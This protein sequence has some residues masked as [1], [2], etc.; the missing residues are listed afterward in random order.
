MSINIRILHESDHNDSLRGAAKKKPS[1]S[2]KFWQEK[3]TIYY[4]HNR[5]YFFI[6][7]FKS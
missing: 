5:G 7:V 2:N 1:I 6:T 3:A 4:V